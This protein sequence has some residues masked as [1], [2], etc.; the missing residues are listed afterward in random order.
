MARTKQT[1]RCSV[2]G[3]APRANK[4]KGGHVVP[5]NVK[6]D[7]VEVESDI[8]YESSFYAHFFET[9]KE[10]NKVFSP[11]YAVATV[12]NPFNENEIEYWLSA[13]FNSKYDGAGSKT[14][15]RAVLNLVVALD[16]SG[17]MGDEF[18]GDEDKSN[19]KIEVAK[20]CLKNLLSQLEGDDSFGLLV[21]DTKQD[22][23]QPLMKWK[24]IDRAELHRKIDE[25]EDRGG[26]Q[27]AP[28]F[29]AAAKMFENVEEGPNTSN[30]VFFMTDME[31][32]PGDGNEFADLV[33]ESSDES[34]WTT[35]VGVGL[36]LTSNIIER[37]SK[38]PGCNYANVRSCANFKELLETEFA[39]LVTPIGF[40]I[41]LEAQSKEFAIVK[42]FGSPEVS[43]IT[44]DSPVR[45]STEFP[46]AQNE[47]GERRGG[48]LLF[49]I[50]KK[51]DKPLKLSVKHENLQGIIE[52]DVQ[53]VTFKEADF[54]QD[55]GIRKSVLLIRYTDFIK[56][57]TA[58][59]KQRQS[60]KDKAAYD[61]KY[62]DRLTAF[63]KYFLSEKEIVQDDSLQQEVD[64][65]EQLIQLEEHPD[66]I[67]AKKKEAAKVSAGVINEGDVPKDASDGKRRS[68]RKKARKN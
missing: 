42:G 65:V 29:K 9:G 57:Y 24:D 51:G 19:I 31:V 52:S 23:L 3:K 58:E 10:N 7:E 37:V 39:F 11:R 26:T 25:I 45:I 50:D 21:F 12:K 63:L 68:P 61:P 48:A 53:E 38:T 35:V 17:S 33:K 40:N 6:A 46:S 34:R 49:R 20:S 60:A 59:R 2:G 4:A 5:D 44:K 64:L 41:V 22:V 43:N 47:K 8:S 15:H 54:F 13:N 30:R 66:V 18:V 36:D 55:N 16:I 14:H 67:E 1:A 27:V 62:K 56:E 32:S 28:A